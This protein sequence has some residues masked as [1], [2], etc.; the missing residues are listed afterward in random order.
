MSTRENIQKWTR[1]SSLFCLR[2]R[3][4]SMAQRRVEITRVHFWTI[5]PV[6]VNIDFKAH[7]GQQQQLLPQPVPNVLFQLAQT[8]KP[9]NFLKA[10][11]GAKSLEASK[12]FQTAGISLS[13]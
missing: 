9:I 5:S 12:L 6:W 8:A 2:V 11:T 1:D 7:L 10:P 3:A 13:V 4:T